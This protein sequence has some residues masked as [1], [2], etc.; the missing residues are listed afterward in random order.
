MQ[1]D[2][3]MRVSNIL[4]LFFVFPLHA[5]SEVKIYC[6]SEAFILN[7][8]GKKVHKQTQDF[9]LTKPSLK[10]YKLH[11][12][13]A[14]KVYNPLACKYDGVFIYCNLSNKDGTTEITINR[15]NGKYRQFMATKDSKTNQ[16]LITSETYGACY[17][18][19]KVL[20]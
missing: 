4:F 2:I 11:F 13:H 6:E 20:F 19:D 1:G 16:T 18:L 3:F 7:N 17:S 9:Y 5:H 8:D 10:E 12:N 14:M 15:A